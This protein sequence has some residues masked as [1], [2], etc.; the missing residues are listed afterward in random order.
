M[1]YS[2][3]FFIFYLTNDVN[4]YK[5]T[6]ALVIC[7]AGANLWKLL[8]STAMSPCVMGVH[9]TLPMGLVKRLQFTPGMVSTLSGLFCCASWKA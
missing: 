3:V 6:L 2:K 7:L 1:M 9:T 5:G 8:V 4:V